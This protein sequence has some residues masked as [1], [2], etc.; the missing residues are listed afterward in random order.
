MTA[1]RETREGHV[2]VLAPAERSAERF[3]P[4]LL[5]ALA[6]AD[7]DGEVRAVVVAGLGRP[8][9][10]PDEV[11][12]ALRRR[13][14]DARPA[15][16]AALEGEC[17]GAAF[18]LALE[19]DIRIAAETARLADTS[20]DGAGPA[21]AARLAHLVGE[22]AARD[23]ALTGRPVPAAEARRL[24]LVSR[25]VPEAD[26]LAEVRATAATIASRAPL[27]VA[28]AKRGIAGA[29]DLGRREALALEHDLFGRLAETRDHKAALE[30]FFRKARPVF[31]GA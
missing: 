5:P 19:F 26:L 31:V 25:V 22:A 14:R 15:T 12:R 23:L 20:A 27:S 13:V 2:V 7:G 21:C 8:G 9:P 24:G 4:A 29:R 28:A 11:T 6:A 1:L 30:A 10:V 17:T 3:L 18:A 16:V